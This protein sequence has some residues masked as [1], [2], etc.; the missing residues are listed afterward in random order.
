MILV[1]A[2]VLI[3]AVDSDSAHHESSRRWLEEALSGTEPVGFAWVVLLAFLRI[4]T[5]PGILHRPLELEMAMAYVDSWLAQ[6]YADALPAE[7]NHWPLLRSL[8]RSAG[9]A[10]NLSSDAH[11]AALAVGRGARV[12]S[13]D[14]DFLRFVGLEVIHPAA[15]PRGD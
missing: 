13:T 8:I 6:P 4:T 7:A 10:G 15:V 11:L 5:R 12:C 14:R 1:D 3:Y 2:N 9:T